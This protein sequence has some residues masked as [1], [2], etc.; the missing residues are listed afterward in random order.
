[1]ILLCFFEAN[2]RDCWDK[3]LPTAVG[4]VVEDGNFDGKALMHR[5]LFI[6]IL[7]EKT[8]VKLPML[9]LGDAVGSVVVI[10]LSS[11]VTPPR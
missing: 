10:D 4:A 8:L 11:K 9:M 5:E 1:M 6:T 2:P 3:I 7:L